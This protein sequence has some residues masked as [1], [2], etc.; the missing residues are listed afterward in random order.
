VSGP[1]GRL[2]PG[3]K[4]SLEAMLARGQ[5]S[6]LL[7]YTLGAE[8]LKA[9]EHAAAVEHLELAVTL[10]PDYSAAWRQLGKAALA[11]GDPERALEVWRQGIASAEHRGDVQAAKEMSVF[12]RR[13][14]KARSDRESRGD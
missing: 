6:A 3:L 14:G 8:C 13:L 9:D 1:K 4:S 11:A 12:V 10:D 7:R 5:D 2:N